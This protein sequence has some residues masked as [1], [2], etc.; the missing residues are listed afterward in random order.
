[1]FIL[2]ADM[3]IYGNLLIVPTK[4]FKIYISIYIFC[5]NAGI[6]GV[7]VLDELGFRSLG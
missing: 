4:F 1:M 5:L 7:E 3:E 2:L 6:L